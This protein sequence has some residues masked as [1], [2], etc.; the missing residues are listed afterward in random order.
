MLSIATAPVNRHERIVALVAI[1]VLVAVSL[2]V[3]PIVGMPLA[4]APAALPLMLGIALTANLATGYL[5]LSQF[6][7]SRLIGMAFL[8]VAYL[9]VALAMLAFLASFPALF[10]FG[11]A[12]AVSYWVWMVWHVEFPLLVL[13]A[14]IA[15]R[16]KWSVA[17]R[18]SAVR[19]TWPFAIGALLVVA[20][21]VAAILASGAG[22]PGDIHVD[23]GSVWRSPTGEL[24][25]LGNLLVL[26]LAIVWTQGRTVLQTWLI[27]AL[28]AAVLEAQLTVTSSLRY[29][30]GWYL[31]K[32]LV[33]CWSTAL[34]SAYLREM[35]V[36][37]AKL[38]DLSMVDGLTGLPNRRFF[39]E[40][41]D[42]AIRAANRTHRPLA[43]LLA[44]VDGFKQFN[45]T[46][47]HLAGD[48]TL[49]AVAATLRATALR[50]GDVVARWGGDEFVAVLPETDLEGAYLV[51]ERLRL[52]VE[53]L[54]IAHRRAPTPAGIVTVCV[55]VALLDER[56]ARMAPLLARADAALYRVK[57]D[58]RNA[59]AVELD[60][61][62]A[63]ML[64]L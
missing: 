60:P 11:V 37:F 22:L 17:D 61:S 5:L 42:A 26:A 28:A 38:S 29:T 6:Q 57:Q 52:S 33:I 44:D 16:A 27:V 50:P 10:P 55:G 39:E 56:D 54:L 59:V 13:I 4:V 18:A 20:L 48:E 35:H 47:G 40:R 31:A 14:L 25:V 45:D 51:A 1:L 58:G 3:L 2:A 41:L 8:G 43:L 53:S 62:G 7:A 21:P 15:D 32:V 23:R 9:A 30:V 12:P 36:L 46:Y 49:K 63:A 34:L 19:W 64:G 24:I